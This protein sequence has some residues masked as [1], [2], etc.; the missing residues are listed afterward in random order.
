MALARQGRKK[1]T[2]WKFPSGDLRVKR[3][4]VVHP[5][6]VLESNSKIYGIAIELMV[7]KR[8]ILCIQ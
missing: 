5:N 8:K 2:F 6:Y 4:F 7:L 1:R 3:D